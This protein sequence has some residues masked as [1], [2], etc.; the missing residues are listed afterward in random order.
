MADAATELR[1]VRL[2][3]LRGDGAR[4]LVRPVALRHAGRAGVGG[5]PGPWRV[6]PGRMPHGRLGSAL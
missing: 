2:G 4:G 3:F 5:P 1:A 6:C